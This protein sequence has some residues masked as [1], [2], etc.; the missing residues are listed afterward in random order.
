MLGGFERGKNVKYLGF[1]TFCVCNIDMIEGCG[2]EK[3]F[4]NWNKLTFR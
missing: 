2:D 1:R 4:N 3:C